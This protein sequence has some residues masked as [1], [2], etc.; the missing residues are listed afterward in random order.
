MRVNEVKV[1]VLLSTM[2]QEDLSI[3]DKMNI[4]TDAIVIN[5]TDGHAFLEQQLND[6]N[7]KMYS[8]Q[9]RGIGLSRNSAL[10][11]SSADICLIADDDMVYEDGYEE[12]VVNE[13]KKNPNADMIVFNVPI[14]Q[15]NGVTRIKI[16]KKGRVR[17]YNGLK[18]GTVNFAFKRE[19]ILKKNISFSLLFGA[20]R[21]GSG[22]DSLFL[23]DMLKNKLKIYSST[24]V[25]A[26]ITEDER[27]SSW[28]N[29]F[30]EKYFYDRGAL[31]RAIGGKLSTILILQFLLRQR[32]V[33]KKKFSFKEVYTL[34]LKGSKEFK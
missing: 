15:K 5:Q 24:K 33:Y 13:F 30:D 22:E 1:E 7:I 11:R 8:F 9:E 29:G 14:H 4:Q 32:R 28:F 27:E 10:L 2:N 25:I 17:L 26:N 21:Y 3:V 12:I 23:V 19:S 16:R 31:F 20:A 34:M 6:K 18:Y